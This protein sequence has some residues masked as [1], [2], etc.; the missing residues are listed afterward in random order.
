MENFGQLIFSYGHNGYFH[1]RRFILSQTLHNT[2]IL[3]LSVYDDKE[4]IY[5][6]ILL[7]VLSFFLT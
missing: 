3:K 7:Y 6:T 4:D 2:L 1:E 5:F